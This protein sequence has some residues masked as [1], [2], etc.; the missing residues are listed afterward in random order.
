MLPLADAGAHCPV[1]A[2]C[3]QRP[4]DYLN[5]LNS[6]TPLILEALLLTRIGAAIHRIVIPCKPDSVQLTY[7]D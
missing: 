1:P 6:M 3:R 7:L 2:M 4:L 5:S